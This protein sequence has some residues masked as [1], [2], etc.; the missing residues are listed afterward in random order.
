L[1]TRYDGGEIHSHKEET[2]SKDPEHTWGHTIAF[3]EEYYQN[4]AE[5]LREVRGEADNI[6]EVSQIAADALRAGN[7]VYAN[8]V[9]GHMPGAELANDRE[10]N[11]AMFE[12]C[13]DDP[14]NPEHYNAMKQG[15][16]LLTN[17]VAESV[18]EMRDRGV[19]VV[20]FTTCYVNNRNAPPG[21]V[22]PNPNDWMPEDVATRV[23]DS[24]IPWE[25]GLVHAPEIPEFALCP[26]SANATNSIHW[27][28]TAEVA[29]VLATGQPADGAKAREYVDILLSRI[30]D[31]HAREMARVD[32]IAV[33]I[34]KRIISG[35][36]YFVRSRNPGVQSESNGVAQGPMFTN[37]FQPRK[38][39][40]RDTFLIAAVS[41]DDPQEIAWAEEARANGNY[42]VGI[43]PSHCQRLPELCDVFFDDRCDEPAGVLEIPGRDD[44]ICPATGTLNNIIMWMLTAQFV[45]EMCRRGAVPYFWMGFY[46]NGRPYNDV[47]RPFFLERGY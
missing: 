36:Y 16:V 43:G 20:V 27:M 5:L 9:I 38:D 17:H 21:K 14:G 44:K 42:V 7:K 22:L 30:E 34:A 18:K 33:T 45:D 13:P 2:V 23:I 40:N 35:G 41:A 4:A 47:M 24:H 10:G 8:I 39:G 46:R 25:Q 37:A 19:Y 6:T 28:I 1:N 3:G 15:D 12:F 31:F 11:P 26:G 32:E 29:N